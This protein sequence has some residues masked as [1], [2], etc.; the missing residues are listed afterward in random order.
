[1]GIVLI[2]R[3]PRVFPVLWT[4]V[5]PFIDETT[6]KK[7]MITTNES[8]LNELAKYISK[9][10]LPDFLGGPLHFSPMGSFSGGHIPKTE[11]KIIDMEEALKE[12]GILTSNYHTISISRTNPYGKMDFLILKVIF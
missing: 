3:A 5:S 10:L 6:R 1:M 7:F 4:L 12:D 8:V 11:Y 2:T 9:D